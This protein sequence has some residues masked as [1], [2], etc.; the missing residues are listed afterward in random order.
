MGQRR[1]HEVGARGFTLLELIVTLF[2]I[3]LAVGL[4]A[5]VV[6][7]STDT[8]RGRANVARFSAMLRHARDQAITTRRSHAVVIDPAGHRATLVAAPDEVRQARTLSADL[9]VD[10][11][12]PDALN[13]R[14]EPTGVSTGGDFRL[15]TGGMRFRVT[16]DQ[17]TGRVRVEREQ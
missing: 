15:T 17:L 7:R 12:P 9:Q 5:P 14:F 3:A 4:V 1:R 8:L 16:V 6:G 2:V 11:N 10:A 13:V